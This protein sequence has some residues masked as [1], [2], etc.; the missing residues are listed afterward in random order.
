M[1]T[2][3]TAALLALPLALIFA[4]RP[5]QDPGGSSVGRLFLEGLLASRRRGRGSGTGDPRP[6][7]ELYVQG[8]EAGEI[9]SELKCMGGSPVPAPSA[10]NTADHRRFHGRLQDQDAVQRRAPWTRK[11]RRAKELAALKAQKHLKKNWR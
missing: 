2:P 7:D 5:R 9:K 6:E 8:R 4:V 11:T 3:R 10:T 1:N